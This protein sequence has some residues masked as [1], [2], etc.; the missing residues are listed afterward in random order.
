MPTSSCL[1]FSEKVYYNV[2]WTV[3][4]VL[5]CELDFLSSIWVCYFLLFKIWY[6]AREVPLISGKVTLNF[7]YE[8]LLGLVLKLQWTLAFVAIGFVQETN[9]SPIADET[10]ERGRRGGAYETGLINIHAWAN[11]R[12]AAMMTST[13]GGCQNKHLT[14]CLEVF[15]TW[16][17][18]LFHWN[19]DKYDFILT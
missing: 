9:N 18:D 6:N 13:N 15:L 12:P 14:T 2:A 5:Q 7:N 16:H 3:F 11:G 8:Y 10:P 17:E 1:Q 4:M 19:K